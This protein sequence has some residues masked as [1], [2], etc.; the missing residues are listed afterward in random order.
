MKSRAARIEDEI[1]ERIRKQRDSKGD[2]RTVNGLANYQSW[3]DGLSEEAREK[4]LALPEEFGRE[5]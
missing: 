4:L 1:I 3:R 2:F 5:G